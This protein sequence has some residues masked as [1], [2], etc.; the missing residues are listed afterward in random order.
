ML[1]SAMAYLYTWK[2]DRRGGGGDCWWRLRGFTTSP[3]CSMALIIVEKMTGGALEVRSDKSL[4]YID[5]WHL[6]FDILHL[7]FDI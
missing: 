1:W 3:F 7:A 5:L 4:A 6:I 2:G